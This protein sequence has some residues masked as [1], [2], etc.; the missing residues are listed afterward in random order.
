MK[1]V[2][3]AKYRTIWPV[4]RLCDALGVSSLI[5][6][7]RLLRPAP[8]KRGYYNVTGDLLISR[9]TWL[10]K[11]ARPASVFAIPNSSPDFRAA[12]RHILFPAAKRCLET[13]IRLS[14][15]LGEQRAR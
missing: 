15:V 3:I 4:A 11:A 8:V 10:R 13:A 7:R 2:F 12:M 6:S 14:L 9:S 1:F 5:P